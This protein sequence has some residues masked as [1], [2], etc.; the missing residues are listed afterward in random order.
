MARI[1]RFLILGV[2]LPLFAQ[3]SAGYHVTQTY[4]LGGDGG[5]DYIVPEPA[6]HRVFIGRT[7][8]VMVVDTDNGKLLGEVAGI[9]GAHGA[10]LWWTAWPAISKS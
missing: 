2:A 5:W 10:M 1:A 7:N 8:R 3:S 9:K 4:A 6:Q